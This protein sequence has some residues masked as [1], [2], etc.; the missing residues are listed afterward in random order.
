MTSKQQEESYDFIGLGSYGCVIKPQNGKTILKLFQSEDAYN[1]EIE[2]NQLIKEIDSKNDFTVQLVNSEKLTKTNAIKEFLNKHCSNLFKKSIPNEIFKIEYENGGIDLHQLF[3]DKNKDILNSINIYNFF[4]AFINIF[5]GIKQLNDKKYTHF[6]IKHNNIVFN[7]ETNKFSLIDFGLLIETEK[8]YYSDNLI[9]NDYVFY[10]P[11]YTIISY[12]YF[13]DK[14]Y[15]EE[16]LYKSIEAMNLKKNYLT[17]STD[18]K[19]KNVIKNFFTKF[20]EI[21]EPY[22]KLFEELKRIFGNIENLDIFYSDD[23]KAEIIKNYISN[24]ADIIDKDKLLSEYINNACGSV[25]SLANDIKSKFDVFM[26]G[27]ALL[28]VVIKICCSSYSNLTTINPETINKIF[29]VI[30]FM[31]HPNPCLRYSSDQALQEYSAI[32]SF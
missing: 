23:K 6:D 1:K 20:D 5:K 15:D 16:L 29:N 26:L 21:V 18:I 8:I 9:Y 30:L 22:E 14:K 31:I 25:N 11:E 28:Y 27:N 2:E 13:K 19:I 24:D 10:P 7:K 4:K 12:F 3:N 32:F 17:C